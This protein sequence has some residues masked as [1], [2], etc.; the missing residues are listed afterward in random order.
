MIDHRPALRT[1]NCGE[2]VLPQAQVGRKC[3]LVWCDYR[4]PLCQKSRVCIG[5]VLTASIIHKYSTS[6]RT[7]EIGCQFEEV[8]Q[9]HGGR[10][11]KGFGLGD[12][13]WAVV[14]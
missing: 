2:Y 7:C 6:R 12:L 5:E 10:V 11:K 9:R 4:D 3:F 8:Q 1:G 13:N 14:F